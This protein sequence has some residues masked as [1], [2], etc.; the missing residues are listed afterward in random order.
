MLEGDLYRFKPGISK[1]FVTR[2]VQVSDHAFRY[3][4]NIYTSMGGVGFAKPIVAVPK[5][6]I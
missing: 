5:A 4:K 6:A 3:F 1:N 2:Y